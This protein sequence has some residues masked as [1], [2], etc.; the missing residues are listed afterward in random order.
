MRVILRRAPLTPEVSIARFGDVE[1]DFDKRCVTRAGIEVH[2]TVK[3]YALLRL[4]FRHRGKV[5]THR[6]ILQDVWGPL[7]GSDR[8]Y[9]R[10]QIFNLRR[11]LAHPAASPC[12]VKTEP[13]IGYRFISEC[14]P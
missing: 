10:V 6:Q 4:L 12:F 9:L 14:D 3:D 5:V 1:V 7:H 11:K 8:H 13:G 2:L